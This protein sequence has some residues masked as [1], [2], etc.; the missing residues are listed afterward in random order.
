MKKMSRI[1]R[2]RL[3]MMLGL[4]WV[5]SGEVLAHAKIDE[6]ELK[7]DYSSPEAVAKTYFYASKHQNFDVVLEAMAEDFRK[8]YGPD[9]PA[10]IARLQ[11]T[12]IPEAYRDLR[13]EVAEVRKLVKPVVATK[14]V[15]DEADVV[16]DTFVGKDVLMRGTVIPV[17]KVGPVWK[18][19]MPKPI[20]HLPAQ[21]ANQAG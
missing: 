2:F 7:V 19:T 15:F 18:V 13:I 20:R 9:K 14:P 5:F 6:E 16:Y 1:R 12:A 4:S 17:Q 10:Q 3:L 21:K 11:Q 8:L